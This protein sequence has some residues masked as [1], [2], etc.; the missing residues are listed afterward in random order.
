MLVSKPNKRPSLS[1]DVQ[2][3]TADQGMALDWGGGDF[4]SVTLNV[5][6]TDKCKRF[7]ED[8]HEILENLLDLEE[9][10]SSCHLET[11]SQNILQMIFNR[12]FL[13]VILKH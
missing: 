8:A 11:L 7:L 5:R 13:D 3:E 9:S 2:V 4:A 6:F 10:P 12:R 1:P